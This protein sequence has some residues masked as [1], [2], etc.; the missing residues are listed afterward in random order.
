MFRNLKCL[1]YLLKFVFIFYLARKEAGAKIKFILDENK[2]S[3]TITRHWMLQQVFSSNMYVFRILF[4][5]FEITLLAQ[6]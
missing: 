6:V 1:G 3:H 5:S 4:A 2:A